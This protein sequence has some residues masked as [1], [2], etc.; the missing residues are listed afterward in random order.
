MAQSQ[1]VPEKR[2]RAGRPDE[3]R[4]EYVKLAAALARVGST[5]REIAENL[6]INQST[7]YRWA[8][9]QPKFAK[10]IKTGKIAADNR[11]VQSL[12]RRATGYSFDSVKIQMDKDGCFHEHP[13]VEH[14]PPDTTAC[15]FWL[16]NRDPDKWRDRQEH[17][18]Q[19]ITSPDDLRRARERAITQA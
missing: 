14:V 8:A 9:K 10:A 6:G 11:V 2:G 1:R 13:Y 7:L 3:F 16:K 17:T 19:V 5:D 18:L 4:P 12:Y 15:I